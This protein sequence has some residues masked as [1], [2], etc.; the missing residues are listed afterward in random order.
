MSELIDWVE[1]QALENIRFR[2]QNSENLAKEAS[3]TLTLLLAGIGGAL[4]YAVKGFEADPISNLTAGAVALAAWFMIVAML[5]VF[6]CLMTKS[7]PVPTN[8]PSN[9]YNK[10]MDFLQ[11]REAELRNLQERI[12]QIT[13]R[14]HRYAAW[15]DRVRLIAIAS[16]LV[17][18]I[19]AWA[20]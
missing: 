20:Y 17:F 5:L 4:A 7:L 3:T 2:L 9:L 16:P 13:D 14:N 10:Q 15:L 1:K 12:S 19:A 8:E 11:L 18:A 6:H